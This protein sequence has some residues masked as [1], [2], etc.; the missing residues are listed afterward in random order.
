[1]KFALTLSR[2][3]PS[4]TGRLGEGELVEIFRTANGRYGSTLS[5]LIE[6]ADSLRT[7]GIRDRDVERLVALARR[8]ALTA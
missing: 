7:C 6:T 3:S 4:H 2:Q 8:H 5:Y 1:M